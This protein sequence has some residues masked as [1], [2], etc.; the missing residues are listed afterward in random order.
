[1]SR[2]A[3]DERHPNAAFV[4]CQFAG[5]EPTRS[6]AVERRNAPLSLAKT[7]RVFSSSPRAFNPSSRRPIC[8]SNSASTGRNSSADPSVSF[9]S[10]PTGCNVIG[11]EIDEARTITMALENERLVDEERDPS[12]HLS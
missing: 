11:P 3:D 12:F 8:L 4:E 2:P 7:T 6:I 10:G 1:M 5:A 9:S